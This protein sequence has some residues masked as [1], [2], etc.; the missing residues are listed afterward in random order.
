MIPVR[1]LNKYNLKL[2]SVRER[3]CSMVYDQKPI[4]SVTHFHY[5][6]Y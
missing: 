4:T 1:R 2:F 5:V 6:G 3:A